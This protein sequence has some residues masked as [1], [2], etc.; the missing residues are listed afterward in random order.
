MEENSTKTTHLRFFG[1]PKILPFL[2]PYRL[3]MF[4]MILLAVGGSVIDI[5]FPKCQE[6]T[7]NH[8]IGG[9][10]LDTFV[11]FC[12]FYIAIILVK[13]AFDLTIT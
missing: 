3:T 10:T 12:I 5:I 7:I 8:F 4:F 11:P 13:I 6:Y 9:E 1:I 2:K